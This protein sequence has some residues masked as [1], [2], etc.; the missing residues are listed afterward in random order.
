[1]C[2]F[3]G[4]V[5][6]KPVLIGKFLDEPENS[7]IRQSRHSQEGKLGLHGDGFGLSWYNHTLVDPTPAIF[8]SVQPAWNDENLKSLVHKVETHCLLG[9]VRAATVGPV[10]RENCHPFCYRHWSYVHNGTIVGFEDIKQH[11]VGHLDNELYQQIKGQTDSEHFFYLVLSYLNRRPIDFLHESIKCAVSDIHQWQ[12]KQGI[13][14][15]YR[16]NLLMTDGIRMLACRICYPVSSDWL[17]LYIHENEN[18]VIMSSERL[19]DDGNWHE[20]DINSLYVID[21]D[22][23][24]SILSFSI[25]D[26]MSMS[27]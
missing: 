8:K 11:L 9:H 17:S 1:M 23:N 26:R 3:V 12:E 13:K 21:E 18:T 15:A 27:S 14:P 10:N 5:S 19:W 16:L 20:M 4:V 24:R 22:F 6:K 25:P 7:L 2:R